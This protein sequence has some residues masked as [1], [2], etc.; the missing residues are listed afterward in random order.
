M[1]D[2]VANANRS[3]RG[4]IPSRVLKDIVKEI[5]RAEEKHPNYPSQI[6]PVRRVGIIVEEAGEAMREALDLTR[7]GVSLREDEKDNIKSNL[8]K[9]TVETAATAIRLLK[10]MHE[11]SL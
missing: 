8:Y 4:Y 7:P 11:E 6:D 1:S 10:A 5:S 2:I 3:P 9:E